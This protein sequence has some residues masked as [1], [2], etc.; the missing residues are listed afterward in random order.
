MCKVLLDLPFDCVYPYPQAWAHVRIYAT[1]LA[2]HLLLLIIKRDIASLLSMGK[3]S[4]YQHLFRLCDHARVGHRWSCMTMYEPSI[5]MTRPYM[6]IYGPPM[7][8]YAPY[9]IT[10]TIYE[11]WYLDHIYNVYG[12]EIVTYRSYSI[13]YIYIHICILTYVWSYVYKHMNRMSS[14]IMLWTYDWICATY[15]LT[16]PLHSAMLAAGPIWSYW[17]DLITYQ[18]KISRNVVPTKYP[19]KG[20]LKVSLDP[21]SWVQNTSPMNGSTEKH[22]NAFSSISCVPL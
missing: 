12:T 22:W 20:G 14:C 13:L 19:N 16:W 4:F 11:H 17:S 5:I 2:W 1:P 18:T 7:N 15:D 8:T 10:S 21:Q 9:E 6:I 3:Y